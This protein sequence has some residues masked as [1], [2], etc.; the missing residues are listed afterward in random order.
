MERKIGEVFDYKD[1]KIRIDQAPNVCMGCYFNLSCSD[2]DEEFW[3]SCLRSQRSDNVS[4]IFKK[5]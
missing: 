4:V 2:K 5:I 3:G 1:V